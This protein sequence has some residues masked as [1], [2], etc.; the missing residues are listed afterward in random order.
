[1]LSEQVEAFAREIAGEA[2]DGDIYQLARR[3]AEAQIDLRRVRY[4]RRR[5]LSHKLN[6]S[7]PSAEG[8]LPESLHFA[9]SNVILGVVRARSVHKVGSGHNCDWAA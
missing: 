1:V 2:T 4:A 9:E 6:D 3:I 5:F 7:F 8:R